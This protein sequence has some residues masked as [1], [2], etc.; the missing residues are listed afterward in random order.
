MKPRHLL[1]ASAPLATGL[2]VAILPAALR[3]RHAVPGLQAP[4][5]TLLRIWITGS[6]GG[7]QAWLTK[8]LS[9][10]EAAHPGLS[11]HLRVISP[12]DALSPE[13]VPPDVIL[14]MPGD[15]TSPGN[16][17]SPIAC[18]AVIREPFSRS[19]RSQEQQYGLPLCW[20]AWVLAIDSTLDPEPAAT[21][22][23]ATLLGRPAATALPTAA[24]GYPLAAASAADCA[25]QSPG[26]AALLALHTLLPPQERPPLPDDLALLSPADGYAAFMNRRCATA[27]L[28]TGQA[29]AFASLV[30]AG[31][32]FPFRILTPQEVITDQVWLAALTPDAPE[33][34]HALLAFLTAPEAQQALATQGLHTVR[35]DLTL[36][37]AG[38]SAEVEAAGHIALYAINAYIPQEEARTA[39]WQVFQGTLPFSQALLPLL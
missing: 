5:R 6:P 20:G 30:S 28:T 24:P 25:L 3:Q 13:A 39:A 19:G 1:P 37:A 26:G 29:T 35:D 9:A 10:F 38:F 21:P 4:E 32:G 22:A 8:Q 18:P 15:F 31:K 2:L 12:Q 33:E 27:I 7:G 23:P 16:T 11:T 17:F 34:A 14:H 36:Y